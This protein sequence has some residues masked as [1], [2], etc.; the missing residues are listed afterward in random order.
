MLLISDK[1]GND[2]FY[3]EYTPIAGD[4]YDEHLEELRKEGRIE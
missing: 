3:Q 2:R 1:A 4:L